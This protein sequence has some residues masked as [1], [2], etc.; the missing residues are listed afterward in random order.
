MTS[1]FRFLVLTLFTAATL[2]AGVPRA[3]AQAADPEQHPAA[4]VVRDYLGMIITRQWKKSVDI[5][6]DNSMK[7]LHGDYVDRLA[8]APTMDEEEGMVRRVGKSTIEEVKQMKPREFYTAFHEGLQERYK[9]EEDKLEIIRKTITMK[10]LSVAEETPSLAHVLVRAKY[11]TGERLVER[12]ELVSLV[13]PRDKWLVA[14]N[15]Q[16]PK[17]KALD[18]SP[19]DPASP[20]K[21][22]VDPVKPV[23]PVP[24][25]PA[26]TKPKKP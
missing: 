3:A 9:V 22:A 21:P 23:K 4:K 6:D 25:K 26:T 16:A 1:R 19:A 12:L 13:K 10:V 17:S 15:E 5:V 24:G 11:S 20:G 7:V 2:S 8:H 14:L 18:G